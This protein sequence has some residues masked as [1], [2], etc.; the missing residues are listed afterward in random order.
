MKNA[1]LK[2]GSDMIILITLIEEQPNNGKSSKELEEATGLSAGTIRTR[3][4][5]LAKAGIIKKNLKRWVISDSKFLIPET[6]EAL[7]R[8]GIRIKVN[9]ALKELSEENYENI[10]ILDVSR[11]THLPPRII[12]DDAHLLAHD[13]GL[14]IAKK[15]SLRLD[16]SVDKTLFKHPK[17]TP[18]TE[19]P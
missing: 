6:K 3:T 1:I 13:H 15:S 14:V 2:L 10:T 5:R 4:G 11:K 19:N 7:T 17:Q 16:M 9:A 12:E 18:S 8:A